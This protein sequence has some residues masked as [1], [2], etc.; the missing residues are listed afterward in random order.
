MAFCRNLQ[1]QA[2]ALWTFTREEIE[3]TNNQAERALRRAVLWRKS[4]FGS[5]SGKVLRFVERML[6]VGETCRQN[7]RNG[8]DYLT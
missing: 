5:A 2:D 4:S 7:Q 3:P 6:T 8:L 1:S